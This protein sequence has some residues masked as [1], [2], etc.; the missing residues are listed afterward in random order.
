MIPSFIAFAQASLQ[1]DHLGAQ[2][3]LWL[4]RRRV[5]RLLYLVD[6]AAKPQARRGAAAVM[7]DVIFPSG[8]LR[9]IHLAVSASVTDV[10]KVVGPII[11]FLFVL[12]I[13]A[14]PTVFAFLR[15]HPYRGVI[16]WLNLFMFLCGSGGRSATS[17][18]T[19]KSV[20]GCGIIAR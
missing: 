6:L 1:V 4:Y 12:A 7:I 8:R 16:F 15:K 18:V 19:S 17:A 10:F 9:M 13:G 2:W 5:H 11:G 20:S 3:A 14:A